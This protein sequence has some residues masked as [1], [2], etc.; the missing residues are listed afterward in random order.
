MFKNF[1][2]IKNWDD[3]RCENLRL[4]SKDGAKIR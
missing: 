1:Y 3:G 4:I 2:S